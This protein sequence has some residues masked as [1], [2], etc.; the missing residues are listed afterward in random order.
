MWT[1]GRGKFNKE[2]GIPLNNTR[3]AQFN[4]ICTETEESDWGSK[5]PSRICPSSNRAEKSSPTKIRARDRICSTFQKNT[6]FQRICKICFHTD[7]TSHDTCT[8]LPYLNTVSTRQQG[9]DMAK[10]S[11]IQ[12]ERKIPFWKITSPF[13]RATESV[14]KIVPIPLSKL[15][16]LI[17]SMLTEQGCFLFL[18]TF[19]KLSQTS[20]HL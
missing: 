14:P 7:R 1:L 11:T 6:T 13:P 18:T 19:C 16:P 4:Q 15:L 5:E 12:V 10:N 17:Q 2:N 3:H 8:A 9:Q 20:V